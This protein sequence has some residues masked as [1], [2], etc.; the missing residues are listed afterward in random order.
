MHNFVHLHFSWQQVKS[1]T[2]FAVELGFLV[3]AYAASQGKLPPRK[4]RKKKSVYIA[5]I[6]KVSN[7]H[8]YDASEIT[9]LT[10]SSLSFL[11]SWEDI[12]G[13]FEGDAVCIVF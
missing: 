12:S 6:E 2:Q 1:L 4:R 8:W 9:L 7:R 13:K 5:T 3:E 10:Q 11:E